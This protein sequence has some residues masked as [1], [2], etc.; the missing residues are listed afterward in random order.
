MR[1]VES[2]LIIGSSGIGRIHIREFISLGVKE[3]FI[4]NKNS[5]LKEEDLLSKQYPN[6]KFKGLSSLSEVEKLNIDAVSICTIKE[7]HYNYLKYF[8]ESPKM[9][10]LEKP[11]F[12]FNSYKDNLKAINELEQINKK[13]YVNTCNS[14]FLEYY[15]KKKEVKRIDSFEFYFNTHGGFQRENIAIDLLPH[16]LSMLLKISKSRNIKNIKKDINNKVCSFQ[17]DLDDISCNLIL[18]QDEK[19]EKKL[20]FKINEEKIT[21]VQKVIDNKYNVFLEDSSDTYKVEDPFYVSTK[22]F[23]EDFLEESD[24]FCNDESL[25]NMYLLNELIFFKEN[26]YEK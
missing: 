24:S 7:E 1:K 10:V 23:I 5:T 14:Y 25:L 8:L 26:E 21:R 9:I 17:F 12:W 19:I 2:L 6:I 20:Y 13:L 4:L 16:G 11:F 15:L 3:V 22:S 18:S